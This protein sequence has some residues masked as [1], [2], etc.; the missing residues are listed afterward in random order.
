MSHS[1]WRSLV[2]HTLISWKGV[3]NT[4]KAHF[5]KAVHIGIF[6]IIVLWGI[7]L[8]A[9]EAKDEVQIIGRATDALIGECHAT[10][11][12]VDP[13]MLFIFQIRVC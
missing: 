7:V 4:V 1:L 13:E 11:V 6:S 5:V 2:F 12:A 3:P 8:K 10:T 9:E